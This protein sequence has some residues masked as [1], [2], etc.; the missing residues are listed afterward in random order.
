MRVRATDF[1]AQRTRLGGA[2]DRAIATVL[3][4]GRFV[5]GPEVGRLEEALASRT[6]ANHAITCASGTDA[7]SLALRSIG[8]G[9]GDAVVV[10]AFTFAATAGAVLLVGATPVFADVEPTTF[11]LDA[12]TSERAIATATK[13]SLR[14]AAMIAVDLFGH[15]APYEE[16]QK[17][18]AA[19]GM[20][21]IADAAQSLGARAEGRPVGSL[22]PITTTS[23]F[24]TKPLGCYGDGGAVFTS[25]DAVA[26]K[27]RSLRVHGQGTD[28]YDNVRVGMNSRLD[29]I[30]AAILLAKLAVFDEELELRRRTADSYGEALK[31]HVTV[32][33]VAPRVEPAWALYTVRCDTRDRLVKAL[34]DSEIE[35]AVYYRRPLHQQPAFAA[36]PRGGDLGVSEQLAS[37]VVSLP[38]QP[39]IDNEARQFVEH[40]VIHALR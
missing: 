13:A 25:D 37:E 9:P 12:A 23:F 7:L 16:L 6:G 35:A 29:T 24:P 1:E 30:Q 14:P 31:G 10:P 27:L 22:A 2:V 21:L 40:T 32:P 5:L 26:T 17:L 39:Y 34:V 4:H 36:C 38:I 33:S 3:E 8:V 20:F 19:N 15:P 18:A 11:N 28:K